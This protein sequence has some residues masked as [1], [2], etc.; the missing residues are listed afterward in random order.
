MSADLWAGAEVQV[1]TTAAA[2]MHDAGLRL[3][4]VLFNHGQLATELA[5]FRVP[6]TIIDEQ[7]HGP[8]AIASRLMRHFR[9]HDVDIIHTHR[10]S[11]TVLGAL[12]G[13]LAGTPR[14]VRTVHGLREPMTGWHRLKF[15]AYSMLERLVL[16]SR[17]DLLIAVSANIAAALRDAGYDDERI[18]HIRNGIDPARMAPRRDRAEVR[19]ELGLA[20]D[21]VVIGTAGRLTAV[22]AQADLLHAA[23]LML[24][25]GIGATFLIVGDGPLRR[26][27]EALAV[28]LGIDASCVFTG[29]RADAHSVIAAMDV[30]VL[31]SLHEGTPM[32]LLEA[33]T[34]GVPV[35][36][37][38]VGGVPDVIHDGAT[39][40]L[41]EPGDPQ[42]LAAACV[43]LASQPDRRRWLAVRARRA[44]RETFS[45]RRCGATLAQSYHAVARTRLRTG[46]WRVIGPIGGALLAGCHA[47]TIRSRREL[48]RVRLRASR[49]PDGAALR[50]SLHGARRLLI[51]CHGNI[52]R[53]PFAAHL[54]AQEL[55]PGCA[56]EISSAGLEAVTGT[57]AHPRAVTSAAARGVDLR[58]HA[59][60]RLDA[61]QVEDADVILAMDAPQIVAL[62][63]RYPGARR[64]IFLLTAD[65]PAAPLEIADPVLGDDAVVARCFE[66]VSRGV[67]SIAAALTPGSAHP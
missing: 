61:E 58:G 19:Q 33:M 1:A 34:L 22:K 12:A 28:S 46:A 49:A 41:V 9:D 45:S 38:A 64:R 63:H 44:V 39:G 15:E 54:L 24:A 32:V 57:P 17:A 31:P 50:E 30:F 6:V 10:H 48:E 67:A 51:V 47:I 13:T 56:V 59:A 11:D 14:L 23:R 8:L 25:R 65:A 52:M 36:A 40:L 66:Y 5:R 53:S 43:A 16:R 29:E 42:A 21:A 55:P 26:D 62:R 20:S 3:S 2:L 35:I 37:T 18:V 60:T 4:A 7:R 27:L